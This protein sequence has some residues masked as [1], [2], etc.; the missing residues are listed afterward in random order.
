MQN[1]ELDTDWIEKKMDRAI[2]DE[3]CLVDNP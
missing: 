2:R 1:C 3:V